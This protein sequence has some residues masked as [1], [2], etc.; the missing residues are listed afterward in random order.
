MRTSFAAH[1]GPQEPYVQVY[2]LVKDCEGVYS[3]AD[4]Y[5]AHNFLYF[6]RSGAGGILLHLHVK[7]FS[8]RY[9]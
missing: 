9:S 7:D 8:Y 2:D 1:L 5:L 4:I 3:E 6:F